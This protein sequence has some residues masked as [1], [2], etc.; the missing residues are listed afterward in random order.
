MLHLCHPNIVG[1]KEVIHENHKLYIVMEQMT[2]NLCACIERFRHPFAEEQLRSIVY[3]LLQG[4]AYIH[5]HNVFHR[6]IKPENLLLKGDSVKIGDFGLAREMN[7]RPP[8]TEYIA[9]RWYRAPEIL[10]RSNHYNYAVDLWAVGCIMAEVM[11]RS[12]LF[13][14]KNDVDQLYKICAV[15]GVPTREMWPEGMELARHCGFKFPSFKP[16]GLTRVLHASNPKAIELI[17]A[18]LAWNP[19]D[20]PSAVEALQFPFFTDSFSPY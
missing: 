11:S 5:K 7:S 8:F 1:I 2:E 13:P 17:A 12:P 14:G 18:L 3:Q 15:I 6:D 16:L 19:D 10:L 4:V 9:T 20:R